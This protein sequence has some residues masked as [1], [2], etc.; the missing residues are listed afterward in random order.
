M[1]ETEGGE[2][3]ARGGG[4]GGDLIMQT[5]K[6]TDQE[7]VRNIATSNVIKFFIHLLI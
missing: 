5:S 4:G 2:G 1:K 7:Q 3:G 6:V